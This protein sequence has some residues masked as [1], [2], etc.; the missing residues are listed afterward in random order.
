MSDQEMER[1]G[2]KVESAGGAAT[3]QRWGDDGEG[4]KEEYQYERGRQMR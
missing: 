3:V 1:L 4:G 2:E